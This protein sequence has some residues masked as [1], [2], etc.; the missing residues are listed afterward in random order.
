LVD[1]LNNSQVSAPKI[2]PD[3]CA[4]ASP[5]AAGGAVLRCAATDVETMAANLRELL[6][7]IA[8]PIGENPWSRRW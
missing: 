6:A 1:R 4:A 2:A 5:L 7:F 8:E 3:F